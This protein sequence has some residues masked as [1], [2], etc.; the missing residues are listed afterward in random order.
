MFLICQRTQCGQANH[1][2][3]ACNYYSANLSVSGRPSGSTCEAGYVC[4]SDDQPSARRKA[5][6]FHDSIELPTDWDV[7]EQLDNVDMISVYVALHSS[8]LLH[9]E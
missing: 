6:A 9:W 1:R 2:R 3:S 8:I 4:H 7:S 5:I